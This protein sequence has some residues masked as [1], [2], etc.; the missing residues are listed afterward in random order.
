MSK[1]TE[2]IKASWRSVL[3]NWNAVLAATSFGLIVLFSL[4]PPLQVYLPLVYFVAANA[5]VWTVIELKSMIRARDSS[6]QVFVNM[7]AARPQILEDIWKGIQRSSSKSPAR[8]TL[9]GGRIRSL[10]DIIREVADGLRSGRHA[11]HIEI[12]LSA[13]SPAYLETRILPGDELAESQRARGQG[14][15]ATIRATAQ[16][17]ISRATFQHK[18]ASSTLAV[19]HYESDPQFCG[20]LIPGVAVYIGPYTWSSVDA[21]WIGTEN[22]CLRL[23]TSS[24]GYESVVRWIENR[25]EFNEAASRLAETSVGSESGTTSRRRPQ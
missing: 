9:V 22:S 13:I 17:L 10:S 16:E 21:D 11:G 15:A 24:E 3:R 8:L 12:R 23:S 6:V 20:I 5:V 7:R 2:S 14:Y 1:F 4:L 25:D 19:H 18:L